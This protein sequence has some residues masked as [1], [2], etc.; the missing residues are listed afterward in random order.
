MHKV[1]IDLGKSTV[2]A[3]CNGEVVVEFPPLLA[4]AGMMRPFVDTHADHM[5]ISLDGQG[6][7][8]GESATAGLASRW[9]TDEHK[10]GR[11]MLLLSLAAIGKI[12]IQGQVAVG[13]G[14]PAALWRTDGASLG[15]TLVGK[16]EYAWNGGARK[17]A[18]DVFVLPEPLGSY[19]YAILDQSGRIADRA[20]AHE[21]VAIVDIGY[22]TVDI[23]IAHRGRLLDQS[24]RSTGHGMVVAFDRV[25]TFLSATVGLL[26]DGERAE[27]VQALVKGTP[28]RLK[29]MAVRD[30]LQQVLQEAK[31]ELAD[32]IAGDIRSALSSAEYRTLLFTGGGA[33]WLREHLV[34]QF[35]GGRWVD[36]P[37][38]ANARGFYR[39]AAMRTTVQAAKSK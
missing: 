33:D 30:G 34:Q 4:K 37:R 25:F 12:G 38:Y 11:D 13:T 6:W 22:R 26:S 1:G 32:Q 28:L 29:G 8:V 19:F 15:D 23:V 17:V 3:T 39:Y 5:E 24:T 7:L 9:V 14:V 35:P 18:M 16:H 2:K 36:E 20:L 31:A 27:A 21:P 10:S